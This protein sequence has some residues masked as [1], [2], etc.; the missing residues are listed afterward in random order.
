MKKE[1]NSRITK[2]YSWDF[3]PVKLP[4]Y[5]QATV[6]TDT[7]YFDKKN[8]IIKRVSFSSSFE[9][10]LVEK[11]KYSKEGSSHKIIGNIKDKTFT[12]LF[13]LTQKIIDK[14]NL[15]FRYESNAIDKYEIEYY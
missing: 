14:N 2:T 1:K 8:R 10:P 7:T 12:I 6:I 9:K 5:E 15:N 3:V 13:S 11:Y 4:D